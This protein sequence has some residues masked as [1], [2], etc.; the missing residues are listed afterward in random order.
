MKLTLFFLFVGL[1]RLTSGFSIRRQQHQN[2]RVA[3]KNSTTDKHEATHDPSCRQTEDSINRRQAMNSVIQFAIPVGIMMSNPRPCKAACLSGDTSA[4]CIGIYKLPLDDAVNSYIDTPEHL[5]VISPDLRWV[6]MTEYPKSYKAAK[7]ELVEMQA[8]LKNVTPL[9]LKGDFTAAGMQV[10]GI[11][12]RVTMA[13]RIVL[14]TLESNKDFSMR[15]MR[16]EDAF[17]ELLASLGAADIVIGQ[18]LN[19]SL[20]STTMSQIQILDDVRNAE[21]E[22][23]E[24]MNAIPDNFEG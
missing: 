3:L 12:P 2:A 10:L 23:K 15:Y 21:K 18:A 20:G 1:G 16:T 11:S 19:G 9:V 17:L 7:E 6:P 22:F 24:L 5:A 4:D 13:G 8:K 14:R